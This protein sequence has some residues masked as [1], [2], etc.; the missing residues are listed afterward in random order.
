MLD[1]A[2]G[3]LRW[4]AQTVPLC[5][6]AAVVGLV[7]L[8]VVPLLTWWLFVMYH[9][10]AASLSPSSAA[11]AL[12]VWAEQRPPLVSLNGALGVWLESQ[13]GLLVCFIVVL[14]TLSGVGIRSVVKSVRE[15][16]ELERQAHGDRTGR[17]GRERT[18]MR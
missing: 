1:A 14:L 15:G 2:W 8:F 11:S 7:W 17:R 18:P 12:F 4:V 10:C 5:V 6:R 9:G 16:D 13:Y 3:A